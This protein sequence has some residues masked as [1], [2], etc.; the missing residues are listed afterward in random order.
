MNDFVKKVRASIAGSYILI[1]DRE[2]LMQEIARDF[3]TEYKIINYNEQAFDIDS[4]RKI[5]SECISRSNEKRLFLLSFFSISD[6]AQNALLKIL[7]EPPLDVHIC[8]IVTSVHKL[9]PTIK[10]RC[11]TFKIEHLAEA[12]FKKIDEILKMAPGERSSATYFKKILAKKQVDD[13][14]DREAVALLVEDLV[15]R[16]QHFD[17]DKT[18]AE[19]QRTAQDFERIFLLVNTIHHSYSSPKMIAEYVALTLPQY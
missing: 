17:K 1:G 6:A 15:K 18:A 10:S 19:K 13:R 7:E 5:I 4:A 14:V 8:I 9:L 3:N 16:A 2:P 12:N 11:Q